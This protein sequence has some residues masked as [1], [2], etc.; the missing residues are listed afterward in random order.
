MTST[1]HLLVQVA[2]NLPIKLYIIVL[3]I[4]TLLRPMEFSIKFDIVKSGSCGDPES[5]VR[6]GPTLTGG[7]TGFFS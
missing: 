1:S 4:L 6:G 3:Y 5:F 7:F 2:S